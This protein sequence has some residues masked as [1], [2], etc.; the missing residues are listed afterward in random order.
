M[1]ILNAT[2]DVP[3]LANVSPQTI[4]IKTNNTLT[5]VL[6]AGF[7]DNLSNFA[8]QYWDGQ[9]ALVTTTDQGDQLL[10]ISFGN[11]DISLIQ[12]S[13]SG[14][15][16]TVSGTAGEINSTMG[17]NPVLSLASLPVTPGVYTNANIT[18]DAKGRV[19]QAASGSSGV[20]SV[21][22]S[23][24][25][26]NISGTSTNPI[27]GFTTNVVFP[28]TVTLNA[29][30]VAPLQAATKQYVDLLSAGLTFVGAC[31]LATTG[32]LTATYANGAAGVG[33][34]LTNAGANAALSID[35]VATALTNRILVKNQ[36]S[37]AQNGI[38]TVTTVGDGST[39][40]VLTRA[41]DYD[42]SAEITPG[43][44][45]LVTEGT[46]NARSGWI[47]TATV[48]TIGTSSVSFTQFGV[49]ASPGV[50][51]VT[52]QAGEFIVTNPTTT[53]FIRLDP[54]WAGQDSISVVGVLDEGTWNADT[55]S[56][57]YGGSGRVVATTFALIAGGVTSNGPH[58]SVSVGTS[59]Q[60]L[61]SNGAGILP[62]WVT[63]TTG[64]VS[65]V[66]SADVNRITVINTTTAPVVDISASY[67][68]QSSI[69]TLGTIVGSAVWNAQII[70][71]AKGG[72]GIDNGIKTITLGGSLSTLGAFTTAI[73]VT[74]NSSVTLPVSGVLATTTDLITVN[75]GGTGNTTFTP[76]SV[77]CAGTTATGAFQNVTGVG[78]ATQV[79]TSNG[80]GLLPTWQDAGAGVVMS[81]TS[82]DA[83][84]IT[85]S[86]TAADP[87]VNIS[88][89]YVGQNSITTLGT[90]SGSATWQA[91]II[92]GAYGGTNVNNGGR[93]ITV[94][95]NFE[96]IGAFS[97]ILR[98]SAATDVTLPTTGTLITS[99]NVAFTNTTND[100]NF[101]VQQ[102]AQLKNY[103]E[104]VVAVGNISGSQAFDISTAN[105]FTATVTGTVTIT[106][107]NPAASGQCSSLSMVLTN[108]G[109]SVIT[110]PAAVKWA[111]G[112]DPTLTTAGEDVL[113]FFTLNAGTSWY[114][115]V[116]GQAFA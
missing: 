93:T 108:G 101:N 52:A 71:P 60:Y 105:V 31:R 36:A 40:W 98:V 55:I 46:I 35:S 112:V 41:T 84:R 70:S 21:I 48:A 89:S 38:Y 67:V 13:S 73:T 72:T 113:T 82:A 103:S 19:T 62:S 95:G 102:E 34:T 29:D 56:V 17:A 39:P 63:P 16:S 10:Q 97:T 91:Q 68:G 23:S 90:I 15:V 54:S 99:A 75:H 43:D 61:Q 8:V 22:G 76:Y 59:G 79:L 6:V 33:A 26:I 111:G 11:N 104:T 86:G 100:Y 25:Q 65:S 83:A 69:T 57:S 110:W 92:A 9:S 28:G 3:G 96:T 18:V 106:F 116:A 5:Q 49:F 14:G 32:V 94:A 45:L 27:V 66:T 24:N 37:A 80:A 78:T 109:S 81:V 85:V 53:P 30:P 51:S 114:G 7:L 20:Q 4:Y 115:I 87:T 44:F 42:T 1:T 74:A 107:T 77:L 88:A 58:Q 12:T 47:Q 50:T 64:T 2:S